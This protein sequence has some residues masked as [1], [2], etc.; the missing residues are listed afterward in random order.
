MLDQ[1]QTN[2]HTRRDWTQDNNHW[3]SIHRH[4]PARDFRAAISAPPVPRTNFPSALTLSRPTAP[5]CRAHK[6]PARK[7]RARKC[8]HGNVG[9]EMSARKRERGNVACGNVV[10][11]SASYARMLPKR[12]RKL[13][14]QISFF[15]K[16]G[17]YTHFFTN[18][19]KNKNRY[20]LA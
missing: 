6:S 1:Q 18:T 17:D 5:T 4:F 20:Q 7:C 14:I 10:P 11:P 3:K 15:S 2:I 19:R 9:P 16:T 12:Q 13:K 8:R